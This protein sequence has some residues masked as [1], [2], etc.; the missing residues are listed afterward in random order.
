L[1]RVGQLEEKKIRAA[2]LSAVERFL[3][4]HDLVILDAMNYIKGL[5]YQLF[6]IAR[7]MATPHCIVR[8]FL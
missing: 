4:G 2:M 7:S 3:S 1:L 6:C 8:R 5:R